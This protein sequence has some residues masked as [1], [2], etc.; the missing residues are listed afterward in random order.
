MTAV[1]ARNHPLS[2]RPV[3]DSGP[4]LGSSILLGIVVSSTLRTVNLRSLEDSL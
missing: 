2:K 4:S 3:G 1:A